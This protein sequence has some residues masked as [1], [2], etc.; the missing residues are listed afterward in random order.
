MSQLPPLLSEDVIIGIGINNSAVVS[1]GSVIGGNSTDRALMSFL[2]EA[3]AAASMSKEEVRNFNAFDSSKKYQPSRLNMRAKN[4]TYIKGAPEKIIEKCTK[5]ID[6]NGTEKDLV[7]KNY[8]KAYI[9]S[10]A[11]RSMRLLAVAKAEGAI[12]A[13]RI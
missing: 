10:Q 12:A 1:D 13:M 9:D 7:E 4:I 6:E 3:D 8:L 2:N 11:G 5:Y